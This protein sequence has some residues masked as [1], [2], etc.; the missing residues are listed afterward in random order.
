M[1]GAQTIL[2]LK[3][4]EKSF[5]EP[6]G[7]LRVLDGLNLAVS[8]GEIVLLQGPSG[9][10][11]TTLLQ[12]T[13]CLLRADAGEVEL[14]GKEL[15]AAS[16]AERT[17][18]RQK[19]LGFAFQHFHLLDAL[20]ARENVALGLHFKRQPQN[21]GRVEEVLERLGIARKADKLPRDLS[22]GEKQRVA[23]A[24]AL[25]GK[26]SLLLADEPTSQ[27]DSHS[28]EAVAELVRKLVREFGC[29]ALIATHDARLHS[30]ADRICNLKEG[31]IYD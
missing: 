7:L 28:A 10:G 15:N 23:L 26:P 16:D 1:S 3:I 17:A 11:K 21:A 25:V 18:T 31:K 2:R 20:T 14:A 30:V 5:R 22:G 6:T 29:A 27:L 13:G 24:R 12:I 8:A 9:S 4:V 19:H